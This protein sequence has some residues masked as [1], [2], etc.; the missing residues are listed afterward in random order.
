MNFK[1]KYESGNAGETMVG[2]GDLH[3]IASYIA[4]QVQIVYSRMKSR[5]AEAAEMFRAAMIVMIARPDSPVWNED[6]KIGTGI[7]CFTIKREKER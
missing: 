5:D 1:Y 2:T 3:E 4:R 7:D 6:V